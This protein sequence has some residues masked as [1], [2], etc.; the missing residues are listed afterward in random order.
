MITAGDEMGRTQR[1][2][3]NAWCQDNEIS[4]LDWELDAP[5]E[6]LLAFTR[7]LLELRRTH[8]IFH[9]TQFL[10]GTGS[11]S[12]GLPDAWWFRPDGRRMNAAD[13]QNGASHA[14]GVFFNGRSIGSVDEQGEPI[15]D[16]SFL[17]LLNAHHEDITFTLPPAALRAALAG[18][19]LDRAP[20]RAARLLT[21]RG[22]VH[23]AARSLLLLR[24]PGPA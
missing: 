15:V 23:V 1:G 6:E 7:R 17:L 11:P 10:S 13:W 12:G 16:A 22:G 2:N 8:P 4:W 14:L 19:A 9:R 24:Q 21:A 5:R 3:N 20:G 18:G